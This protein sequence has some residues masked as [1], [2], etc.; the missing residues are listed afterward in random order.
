MKKNSNRKA[1]TLPE[2]Q[3]PV[4]VREQIET[5]AYQIWIANGGGHGS[6]LQHWLQ[7]EAEILKASQRTHPKNPMA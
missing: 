5:R 6:D 3:T 4:S 7:A 2:T 1:T